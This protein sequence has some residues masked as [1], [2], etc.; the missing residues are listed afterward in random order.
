VPKELRKIPLVDNT[1]GR[2]ISYISEDLCDQLIDQFK[3]S[4]FALQIDESTD[5]FIYLCS[6]YVGKRYGGLYIFF[7][8]QNY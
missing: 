2:R 5:V 7:F 8:L 3:T 6:V 1:V 4:R